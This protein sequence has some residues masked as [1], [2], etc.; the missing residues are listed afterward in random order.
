[1]SY[2]REGSQMSNILESLEVLVSFLRIEKIWENLTP[3]V[4]EYF[5]DTHVQARLIGYITKEP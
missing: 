4:K 3:E 5:W 2:G 1:M